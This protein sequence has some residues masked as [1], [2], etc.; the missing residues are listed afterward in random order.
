MQQRSSLTLLFFEFFGS[1]GFEALKKVI[2]AI[3][4]DIPIVLDSKRGDIDTTAQA[5]ASSA[6]EIF[7]ADAVTLSPY[8][9]WDSVQP[10][11][12]GKYNNNGAFILCKTSNPSSSNIQEEKLQNNEFLFEK[13]AKLCNQWNQSSPHEIVG[14]VV[15]ATDLKSLKTIRN[16]SPF[17]WILC[18]GV[19]AQGGEAK[20]VCSVGL[21][22]DGSGLLISVSR[23]ISKSK[24][25]KTTALLLRD[26]INNIRINQLLINN[27]K[28]NNNI[29]ELK[30]YQKEFID[31]SISANVLQ[32]GNFKLKSGRF[33]PYFFNAGLFCSGESLFTV[34]RC[35]AQTIHASGIEFDVIFG[36][37]YKGI[38]LSAA[39]SMA[40]FQMYGESKDFS[41]NRKE[42]KDHG[43]GGLLVGASLSGRKVLIVDDV[44]TAGTAIREA[45][46]LL[47]NNNAIIVAVTVCLDRQE[48]TSEHAEESAIQQVEKEYKFP[49]L[50]IVKLTHLVSYIHSRIDNESLKIDIETYRNKYGVNY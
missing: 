38:S 22:S 1:E 28:D 14:L 34:S 20:D 18:P 15:G 40:W 16:I 2:K 48:K 19:G 4:N 13:V 37:A 50:S 9:G 31:F 6:Y 17:V 25:M 32:F 35:Y 29:N 26:E 5:Y 10:F 39:I 36:P 12:T 7:N 46:D 8:M 42:A 24:D 49:V 45:V 11:V 44:I 47:N 27:N 23:G 21:R 41:Y 3:P 33:S 30:E 43:E